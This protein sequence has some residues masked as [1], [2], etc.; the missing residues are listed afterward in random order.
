MIAHCV[1]GAGEGVGA[2]I[3]Q[4]N[5][6]KRFYFVCPRGVGWGEG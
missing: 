6:L 5:G 3:P 4:D 2:C 1:V